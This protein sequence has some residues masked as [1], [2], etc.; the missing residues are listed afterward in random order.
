VPDPQNKLGVPVSVIYRGRRRL[1][2]IRDLAL[3]EWT[4]DHI[5][6][7]I[8]LPADDVRAFARE[9]EKE[10]DEVRAALAGH[11]AIETAGLWITKKQNRIAEYQAE[12]EEIDE[13]L[14][15][16]RKNGPDF[17]R[18]VRDAI[19]MKLDLFRQTAEELGAYPQR[20]AAPARQGSTVHYVI[21]TDD[22]EAMR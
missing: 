1:A 16:E 17:N 11:L 8:G 4:P 10:I 18:L 3:G 19:R 20:A 6:E 7:Q 15:A 13:F 9:H 2:L 5:A 22:A 14:A 12:A 21:E